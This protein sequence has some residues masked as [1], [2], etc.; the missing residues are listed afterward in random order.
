MEPEAESLSSFERPVSLRLSWATCPLHPATCNFS[1]YLPQNP[2]GSKKEQKRRRRV[3][4]TTKQL[5]REFT[6]SIAETPS[7]PGGSSFRVLPV[8]L[9]WHCLLFSS[10]IPCPTGA[11]A[12]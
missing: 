1:L 5:K 3:S 9:W 6:A 10:A 11:P 4:A 2:H 7:S 8:N 12:I